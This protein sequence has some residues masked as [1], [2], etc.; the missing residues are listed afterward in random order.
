[1]KRYFDTSTMSLL[2]KRQTTKPF[3][4][5]GEQYCD[6]DKILFDIRRNIIQSAG[7][8]GNF[9]RRRTEDGT[10]PLTATALTIALIMA[11]L[12][13]AGP[14]HAATGLV[15]P[16][17]GT[18]FTE[19]MTVSDG[20]NSTV[21]VCYDNQT[22]RTANIT[23]RDAIPVTMKDGSKF[24]CVGNGNARNGP[25]IIPE[26]NTVVNQENND[27][28]LP[29]VWYY[30]VLYNSPAFRSFPL[31]AYYTPGIG[32]SNTAALAADEKEIAPQ[33]DVTMQAA[34]V[35]GTG[36]ITEDISVDENSLEVSENSA[37]VGTA[38]VGGGDSGGGGDGGGGG[39]D[40]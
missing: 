15:F 37:D 25:T 35:S 14:A 18:Y 2:E 9:L 40:E 20:T 23:T 28:I 32:A 36:V 8:I 17:N 29:W 30:W 16:G 27:I 10:L 19:K 11:C 33:G 12:N 38:D 6:P 4:K 7:D 13:N 1:M 31:N 39:G 22:A 26:N 34:S 5:E 3:V 21:Y 24:E